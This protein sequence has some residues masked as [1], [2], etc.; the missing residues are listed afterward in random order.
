MCEKNSNFA[1]EINDLTMKR[2]LL[3]FSAFLAFGLLMTMISYA[4]ATNKSLTSST[5]NTQEDSDLLSE[6]EHLLMNAISHFVDSM[7]QALLEDDKH[8]LA[9]MFKYPIRRSYPVKTITNPE[10]FVQAYD[11]IISPGMRDTILNA[12]YKDWSE[13]GWRGI[14]LHNGCMWID[15]SVHEGFYVKSLDK[16]GCKKYHEAYDLALQR[17][18]ELVGD[19]DDAFVPVQCFITNDSATLVHIWHGDWPKARLDFYYLGQDKTKDFRQCPKVSVECTH[20]YEGSCGNDYYTGTYNGY[21]IQLWDADCGGEDTDYTI[22]G[23][24]IA[25]EAADPAHKSLIDTLRQYS[26]VEDV[27]QS[28]H[29]CQTTYLQDWAKE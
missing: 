17:E 26:D 28:Y 16:T 10:E 4:G 24:Y 15:G 5:T 3:T 20:S 11:M 14:M 7:K 9:Q 6:H 19:L 1:P 13:V 12:T 25:G 8:A 21:Q 2:N 18:R 29:Y 23:F 27:V 22:Y